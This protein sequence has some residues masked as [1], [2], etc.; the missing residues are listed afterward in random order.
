MRLYLYDYYIGMWCSLVSPV[1]D[2]HIRGAERVLTQV[3]EFEPTETNVSWLANVPF[4]HRHDLTMP[5][6]APNGVTVT[7]LPEREIV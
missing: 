4:A 2:L 3:L 7:V 6:E 1:A 5:I